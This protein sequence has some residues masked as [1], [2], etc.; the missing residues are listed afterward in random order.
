MRHK[1]QSF[2]ITLKHLQKHMS[3]PR[4]NFSKWIHNPLVATIDSLLSATLFRPY[5][6]IGAATGACVTLMA[7]YFTAL[8]SGYPLSGIEGPV[9]AFAGWVIGI[10]VD[11]IHHYSTKNR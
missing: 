7:A 10:L 6:V 1:K 9:G 11:I 8:I 5:A 3:M 4:R 2:K